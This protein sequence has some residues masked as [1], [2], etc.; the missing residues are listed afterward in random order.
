MSL[1]TVVFL[2]G[3]PGRFTT[4]GFFSRGGSSPIGLLKT[5]HIKMILLIY[6]AHSPP[7]RTL[8]VRHAG[9]VSS[10]RRR[11]ELVEFTWKTWMTGEG[12]GGQPPGS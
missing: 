12:A 11:S 8:P 7:C 5:C 10:K 1:P 2:R 4:K 6:F 3:G 9:Q